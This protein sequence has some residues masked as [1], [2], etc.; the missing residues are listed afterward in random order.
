MSL[1]KFEPG[2]RSQRTSKAASP[3]LVLKRRTGAI[4]LAEV[5]NVEPVEREALVHQV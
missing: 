4:K 3:G 2:E 5:G 1:A